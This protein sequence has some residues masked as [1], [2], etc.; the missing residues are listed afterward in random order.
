MGV[1]GPLWATLIGLLAVGC[2]GSPETVWVDPGVWRAEASVDDDSGTAAWE[3]DTRGWVSDAVAPRETW[4]ATVVGLPP[5]PEEVVASPAQTARLAEARETVAQ[6]RNRARRGVETRLLRTY[7]RDVAR[8]RAEETD[9]LAEFDAEAQADGQEKIG[10]AFAQHAERRGPVVARLAMLLGFP[11][12]D[13]RPIPLPEET[14]LGARRRLAEAQARYEEVG[15][16][17]AAYANAV[18][19]ILT[20]VRDKMA[21]RRA[22]IE[23]AVA[24][25]TDAAATRAQSDSARVFAETGADY[26][27]VL[28]E[29]PDFKFPALPGRSLILPGG[30]APPPAP[31]LPGG[32]LAG[33]EVAKSEIEH[34]L[35]I[36]LGIRGYQL[37]ERPTGVP[38]RTEE[39][40]A[41]RRTH[42]P[43][44]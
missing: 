7:L 16:M 12:V 41:W 22:E 15:R 20:R 43:G 11:Y 28:A 9:A 38:D 37:A 10:V 23:L 1:R 13:P 5:V 19:A 29:R 21:E 27:A 44:R 36:W 31:V 18:A 14:I 8:F 6:N 4:P 35:R 33:R 40:L 30:T 26:E 24:E 32:T 2:A 39:F 42:R 3:Y 34:D 17:D 25:R